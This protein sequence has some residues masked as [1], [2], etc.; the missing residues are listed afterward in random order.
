MFHFQFSILHGSEVVF[1]LAVTVD[2]IDTLRHKFKVIEHEF[3]VVALLAVGGYAETDV[4]VLRGVH[5]GL[6]ENAA[7]GAFVANEEILLCGA[8]VEEGARCTIGS[9]VLEKLLLFGFLFVGHFVVVSWTLVGYESVANIK[10][11]VE[12]LGHVKRDALGDAVEIHLHDTACLD[13]AEAQSH[14]P[15]AAIWNWR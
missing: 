13:G 3:V 2:A 9:K 10:V 8:E 1:H 14:L 4:M 11:R 6:T 12:E 7:V 5:V 15:I